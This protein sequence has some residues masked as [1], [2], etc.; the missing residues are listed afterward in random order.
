LRGSGGYHPDKAGMWARLLEGD[1]AMKALQ[2]KYPVMY[3][4]PFGGFA[5]MLLQ[6]QTGD[7]D[8][9]PALPTVWNKG[10]ILG[11]RARGNYEVDIEWENHQLKKATIRSFSGNRPKV[12]VVGQKIAAEIDSRIEFIMVK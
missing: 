5:E 9:L 11:L 7:L 8:I 6:S 4:T 1:N 2:L 12:T 10:K 3:D